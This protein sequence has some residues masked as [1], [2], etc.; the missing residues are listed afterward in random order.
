MR[1]AVL[2]GDKRQHILYE[3][4]DKDGYTVAKTPIYH[5]EII[6]GPIPCSKDNKTLFQT[7]TDK[8]IV[9]EEMFRKMNENGCRLFIAGAIKDNVRAMASANAIEAIDLMDL[10][11][12]AIMNAVPTAEGA[13]AAAMEN[14]DIVLFGSRCL[15]VGY[16]RCGK[17]LAN[18]L[19][20]LGTAV[21][22]AARDAVDEALIRSFGLDFVGLYTLE[23]HLKESDFIF[24]TV[25]A[26]LLDRIAIQHIKSSCLVIDIA[27]AP[28]GVDFIAAEQMGIL[29][30]NLPGLPGKVAPRSAAKILKDTI[31]K[32][33]IQ[34]GLP[35]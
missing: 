30:M 2:G 16:G 13:I 1:L 5:D 10:D 18:M 34:R 27:S 32:L 29:A 8:P 26:I 35:T 12:V 7:T 11:E 3:M 33:L 23:T 21:S 28:G 25:P 22:V 17:I 24:N 20:G 9:I 15:V 4:L 31:S 14:S 19:K 6:I